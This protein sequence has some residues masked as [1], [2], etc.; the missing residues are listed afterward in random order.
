MVIYL[1]CK[2]AI[3]Q[4]ILYK[5]TK[6]NR[7]RLILTKSIV[8]FDQLGPFG[9]EHGD[10][11]DPHHLIQPPVNPSLQ[12]ISCLPNPQLCVKWVV[13]NKVTLHAKYNFSMIW[14]GHLH[15][16][17]CAP[18]NKQYEKSKKYVRAPEIDCKWSKF[19]SR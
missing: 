5:F 8:I 9:Y 6:I 17:I 15:L 18:H 13:L 14:I 11:G 7:L 3:S 2:S 10:G 12:K 4:M 19:H 1:T 16:V